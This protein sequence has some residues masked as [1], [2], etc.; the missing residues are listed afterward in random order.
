MK[1]K[2]AFVASEK[3]YCIFSIRLSCQYPFSPLLPIRYCLVLV[4]LVVSD[5]PEIPEPGLLLW[6]LNADT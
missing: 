6:T 4:L 3:S 5:Q 2:L 1:V